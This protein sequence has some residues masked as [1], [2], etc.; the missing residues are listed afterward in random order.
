MHPVCM[1]RI[2]HDVGRRGRETRPDALSHTA[3]VTPS[4]I[5]LDEIDSMLGR[6][7]VVGGSRLN[8]LCKWIELLQVQVQMILLTIKLCESDVV[9][10]EDFN[11]GFMLL[12]R[13]ETL[14]GL[15]GKTNQESLLV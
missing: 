11:E 3:D 5:V 12:C 15:F 9:I 1:F 8:L 6:R 10:A 14:G 13:I 4:I 2:G 7:R